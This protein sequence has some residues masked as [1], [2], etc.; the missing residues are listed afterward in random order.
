MVLFIS[1][2][3]DLRFYLLDYM[4]TCWRRKQQ[5]GSIG[6]CQPEFFW[7]SLYR[8]CRQV[9]SNVTVT[10]RHF[11]DLV[12]PQFLLIESLLRRN[13]ACDEAKHATKQGMRRAN[14]LTHNY[15]NKSFC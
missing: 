13:K 5:N 7:K 15:K 1:A 3:F 4:L 12:T 11:M 10:V 2:K 6:L 8:M 14:N 9:R